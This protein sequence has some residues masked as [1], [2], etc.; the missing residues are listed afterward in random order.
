MKK[1]EKII[2]VLIVAAIAGFA[3]WK[4]STN[5]SKSDEQS[6]EQS[7]KQPDEQIQDPSDSDSESSNSDDAA[8][9][10][11]TSS[12]NQDMDSLRYLQAHKFEPKP[13]I[14]N[15]SKIRR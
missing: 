15:N 10:V 7:D 8:N 13:N 12:A 11:L 4:W 1:S 6:D 2:I 5:K 9:S 3:F 14:I